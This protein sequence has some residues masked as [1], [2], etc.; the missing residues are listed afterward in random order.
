[1]SSRTRAEAQ[2]EPVD[3]AAL[4]AWVADLFAPEP[5]PPVADDSETQQRLRQLYALDR[6]A[7]EVR[8]IVEDL[9]SEVAREYA[10]LGDLLAGILRT[11]GLSP[12]DLPEP[13]ATA[14]SNLSEVADRL[15]LGDLRPE[16]FERAVAL[17]TMA[18][19]RCQSEIEALRDRTEATQRQIQESRGRKARLQ[20]L[21]DERTRAAP[22]EEQK[23]R[24]WE[25]NADIIAQKSAEYSRRLDELDAA[26]RA[27]RVRERGLEYAQIRDLNAAVELLGQAVAEKQSVYDGYAALPPDLSLA[28]LKLEEAKQ[29]RDRLRIECENAVD[30]AFSASH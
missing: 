5:P 14:L 3:R 17:E 29:R 19:F 16:S 23:A 10:A 6:P 27:L 2:P 4:E 20:R 7:R 25:R 12:S 8:A 30:A 28:R 13:T 1:M 26:N 18:A 9:Q 24:E 11:A 22:I 15:G 21:L